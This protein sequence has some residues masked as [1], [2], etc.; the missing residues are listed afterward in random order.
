MNPQRRALLGGIALAAFAGAQA[1]RADEPAP[2]PAA[3][4]PDVPPWPPAE[5]IPL[6][7]G[8][9]PGMPA[10]PPTPSLVMNGTRGARQL[11]AS[12][13]VRPEI[14]V[15]RASRP[16]GSALLVI[17]GG[18]YGFVSLQNEGIDVAH[19]FAPFGTSVF[20]LTYRLPGEGWK[21]RS[22]VPLA[23]AQRAM[24]LLRA[25]ASA[26][27]ID[28]ARI[29]VLGF[30][31]G[32]HLAADLAT[33][34][35]ESCYAAVDDADRLSARPRFVGLGYPVA[36]L[37][38]GAGHAGS[39]DNLLGPNAS[40]TE[41]AKHSPAEHVRGDT[42]PAFVF[43]AMDDDVVPVESSLSWIAACRRARVPIEAHL[44][45]KGGHGF[46]LHSAIDSPAAQ[47]PDL[48]SAWMRQ[49]QA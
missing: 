20:V 14:N 43:H 25:Q 21:N 31:A 28:P 44:F 37:M 6:W 5:R 10:K 27:R 47:W 49:R 12:G 4:A 8:E 36:S 26:L 34:F 22:R 13:I 41:V 45:E 39:R 9:A 29:G 40:A 48:F 38:P 30:S 15:F 33:A 1:A 42:P 35:D 24:R 18:G 7:P 3:E 16:D 19:R 17:P 32:G 11:A 23:D 46:G 2:Q